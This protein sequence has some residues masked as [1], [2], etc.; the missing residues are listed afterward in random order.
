[1]TVIAWAN[2]PREEA[3]LLNPAFCGRLLLVAIT[4][5]GDPGMPFPISFL[6]LPLVLHKR[7]RDKLPET[8]RTSIPIWLQK[9]PELRVGFDRRAAGLTGYTREALLFLLLHKKITTAD[10]LLVPAVKVLSDKEPESE[11]IKDCLRR[12]RFVGRWLAR[13][14]TPATLYALFGIRP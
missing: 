6:V 3:A 10:Q 12:A 5:Y 8:I 2:R 4:E 7:T 1:M 14:G 9:N 11:E 13:G